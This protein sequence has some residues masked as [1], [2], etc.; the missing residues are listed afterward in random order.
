[1]IYEKALNLADKLGDTIQ[2]SR[3]L[4]NIGLIYTKNNDYVQALN[5]YNRSLQIKIKLGDK[6]GIGG[7]L[8]NMGNIY[9]SKFDYE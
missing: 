9:R 3:L 4:N 2:I 8:N 7:I 6:R 5:Y 1:M